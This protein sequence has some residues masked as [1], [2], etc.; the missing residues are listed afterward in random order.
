MTLRTA[1]SGPETG[2]PPVIVAH[3]LF[4]QGRNLGAVSRVLAETRH[5]VACD[6]RNHGESF[7]DE[8]HSYD[9]LAA[10][11]A[12]VI[13]AEG[14]RADVVGHSMGGKAA[15]WLALNHPD[16]VRRLV[17]LDIAPVAYGHSQTDLIDA[18][19]AT[20]FSACRGRS[21][22]D[23][24]LASRI[25]DAG[26]RAFLLQS[27]DLKAAPPRWR[28][29]LGALRDQMDQ[30]VGFPDAHGRRFDGPVLALA[31]GASDYVTDSGAAAFRALFPNG[32]IE[33]IPGLGHWLHAE[34]PAEIAT[35]V[36]GF[37]NG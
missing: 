14:G 19:E 15:M 27:L 23:A 37:L 26:V 35:R 5:V 33:T 21:D 13:G 11:L 24:A 10:D 28:M 30:L 2:L 18:M 22:A 34:R 6:M 9:A 12:A 16:L 1:A 31:G 17:V 3:G 8:D 20:D 32:R 29:N 7:W 36:A 4:G 25:D